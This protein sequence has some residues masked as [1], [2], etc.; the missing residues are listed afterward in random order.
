MWLLIAGRHVLEEEMT[1]TKNINGDWLSNRLIFKL[2]YI[3]F[4]DKENP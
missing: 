3:S 1:I 2:E 4:R